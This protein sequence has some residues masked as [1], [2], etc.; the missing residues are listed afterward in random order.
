MGGCEGCGSAVWDV[1][2]TAAAGA[3]I[4]PLEEE[5]YSI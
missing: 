3:A 5:S 1:L 4:Q 2:V